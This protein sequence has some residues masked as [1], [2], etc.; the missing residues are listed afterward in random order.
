MK[1]SFLFISL[2][3]FLMF[4]LQL[5]AR[6]GLELDPDTVQIAKCF[7]IF[8]VAAN[9]F[10]MHGNETAARLMASKG[11]FTLTAFF[12]AES[13]SDGVLKGWKLNSF[14]NFQSEAKPAIEANPIL[15][16]ELPPYCAKKMVAYKML[17][18]SP[19]K[20]VSGKTF[21]E[22]YADLTEKALRA[23]GL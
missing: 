6:E 22:M 15:L 1:H 12:M 11:A 13:G 17:R 14:D 23:L 9:F 2:C 7:G 20:T 3:Y 4:S 21:D 16:D 18:V 10:S 19:S 8:T 5:D